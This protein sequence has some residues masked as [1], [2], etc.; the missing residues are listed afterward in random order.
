MNRELF[1]A[2]FEQ[3]LKSPVRM[4]LSAMLV[5]FTAIGFLMT[6]GAGI[7]NTPHGYLLGLIFAGGVLGQEFSSGVPHLTF[8]RPVPRHVYVLSRWAAVCAVAVLWTLVPFVTAFFMTATAPTVLLGML[9]A[10]LQAVGIASVV[11][12]LSAGLPGLA[13]LGGLA[14]VGMIQNAARVAGAIAQ[15]A[16]VAAFAGMTVSYVD[17]WFAPHLVLSAAA[18]GQ[19]LS[20]HAVF[21]YASTVVF[22]L[23]VAVLLVN[24][25]QLSYATD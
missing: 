13:D 21:Q 7:A 12:G 10:S 22:W 6:R 24:R 4:T 25:K 1:L 11:L 19:A 3:R 14:A 20:P 9:E 8:T 17:A 16:K 18:Y 2:T 5:F 23:V 15:D